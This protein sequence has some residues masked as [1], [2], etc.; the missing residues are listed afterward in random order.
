MSHLKHHHPSCL[1]CHYP[2]A[3]FDKFCPNC[4]QKPVSPKSSMHDL[5]HEFFHTFWHLDGKFFMTLHHLLIP[6]KLTTEFFK[7]HFKRYAHP[8]QLFLVLGAFAFGLLASRAKTAEDK[9]Q[10]KIQKTRDSYKRKTFLKELDSIRHTLL[11]PQY[12]NAQTQRLSDSLM[13][14]MMYPEEIGVDREKIQK[15][16]NDILDKEF[17]KQHKILEK[18]AKVT[19]NLGE[20][21]G[22]INYSVATEA[23]SIHEL[24]EAFK[25]SII[26]ELVNVA[27]IPL[28][29]RIRKKADTSEAVTPIGDFV[30]GVNAGIK[31]AQEEEEK[32]KLIDKLRPK[33]A[34]IKLKRGLK[35]ALVMHEDTNNISGLGEGLRIPTRELYDSSPDEIIEKYKVEGFLKKIITKQAIKVTQE[36]GGLIHFLMGKLFWA[37]VTMIPALALFLLLLYWRRKRYYVEHIVFLLHFNTAAFLVL[38]PVLWVSKYWNNILPIYF[39]WL[40]IHFIASV[41]RYYQQNWVKTLAKT[42]IISFAYFIIAIFSITIGAIIG[43]AFF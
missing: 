28:E 30:N 29:K 11:P 33:I 15:E 18:G 25:D 38:I 5:L 27:D 35:E 17:N 37:T 41:K 34:E 23:D 6:G 24:R 2:L 42:A 40:G 7:G 14:K 10:N 12:A 16:V 3:E 13:F 43:F 19:I 26:N 8:I 4:G 22:T 20:A 9:A 39:G 1:N 36:A 32:Q 21:N 31:L